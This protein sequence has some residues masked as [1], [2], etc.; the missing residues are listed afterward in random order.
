MGD[1][2]WS[3]RGS[4]II[5]RILSNKYWSIALA[6]YRKH[7]LIYTCLATCFCTWQAI[8]AYF[9]DMVWPFSH[10]SQQTHTHT[11]VTWL[12]CCCSV[13]Q[14]YTMCRARG[15][16]WCNQYQISAVSLWALIP[17]GS[18]DWLLTAY[19]IPLL[20][21]TS[22]VSSSFVPTLY[23]L[24]CLYLSAS[25]AL[26]SFTLFLFSPLLISTSPFIFRPS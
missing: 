4:V 25:P 17:S 1:F 26:H 9:L 21:P 16:L 24:L 18:L 10:C 6:R 3:H 5:G 7:T 23:P 12:R 15:G 11:L 13:R 14:A 22:P 19:A 8:K 20:S 2:F